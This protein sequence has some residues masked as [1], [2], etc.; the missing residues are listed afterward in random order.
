MRF[1]G[2]Y[3]S[4]YSASLFLSFVFSI[5]FLGSSQIALADVNDFTVTN[6]TAD[7]TLT[8]SD[9]QGALNVQET[10]DVDFT[11][12]NHGILR[13]I[14]QKYNGQNQ[15][16]HVSSV[17][18]DGGTETYTTYTSNGNLVLKIGDATRTITGQHTYEINYTAQ[19]VIRFSSDH[20]QLIWNTNGTQWTQPFLAETARLH[21]PA[22]LSS[23]L[24]NRVCY[25]GPEGST[26]HDCTV[27]TEG[28]TTTYTTTATLQSGETMTFAADFP[29]GTFH[30]PTAADWWHD[31]VLQVAEVV[32][33]PVIVFAFAYPYWRRN[34]KDIRGRG[35]IVPE[36]GPPENLGAAE[37]DAINNY[38]LGNRAISATIIDLAIRK[39]LRIVETQSDGVLGIGKHKTFTLEKLSTPSKENL[40]PYEQTVLDG[41]FSSGD[42]VEL[43][44]LK[45]KFYKTSTAVQKA[46]PT[47]LTT[48]GYFPVNP[49]KAGRRLMI[50]AG[51]L[52]L[53]M[54]W[55]FTVLKFAAIGFILAGLVALGFALLMPRRTQKGVDAKDALAGLKLY[56]N[57]AEKDRMAMLQSVDAP[58]AA[59]SDAPQQ[60]VELF[61][62]LLPY[63]MVMGVEQSWAK[64][65]E[66]IYTT[67]PDWYSGNWTAF[68]TGY[69][70][71]SLNDSVSA[72]NTSFAAPSSSGSGGGG[73][74][75]G[76]GGG[77][78]GGGGW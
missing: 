33:L 31:H 55:L 68:N 42:V 77:G 40:R 22:S 53:P 26:A 63:A 20:D 43:K 5:L 6:F 59:K 12:Y 72:M 66:S 50:V 69:L 58:Y 51:V 23:K 71:G 17:K 44:D 54:V 41:L 62:K 74:F 7:Y 67:P 57:T 60:T 24:S 52:I 15:Q 25:T 56:M 45:N 19:N 18:R 49:A 16:L 36:Y 28:T 13:A 9:P 32:V 4:A 76:G 48:Q 30:K 34:G 8:Q 3:R 21:V 70:V 39:Y 64:Q 75:S 1:L 65:F 35:T 10:L 14:P 27:Q 38:K 47:E 2:S 61:E 78:G 29:V 37:A 46:I 11:D 73:G